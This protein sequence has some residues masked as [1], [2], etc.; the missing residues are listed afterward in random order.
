M[1]KTE[2]VS[3]AL[4]AFAVA[5]II[6]AMTAFANNDGIST[7]LASKLIAPVQLFH[8]SAPTEVLIEVQGF[9]FSEDDAINIVL[10][11]SAFSASL[12][13]LFPDYP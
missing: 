11:L 3:I 7:D 5:C 6:T 2:Y 8:E 9:E 13:I 12:G 4:G 10:V 1:T